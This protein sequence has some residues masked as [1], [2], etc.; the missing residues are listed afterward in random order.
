MAALLAGCTLAG[1]TRTT[2]RTGT[3]APTRSAVAPRPTATPT[4]LPEPAVLA[5]KLAAVSRSGIGSSGIVVLAEDGTRL[6]ARGAAHPLAPAST[7]KVLTTLAA[8]D[9]L[10]ADHRFTTRVVATSKQRVVLVG[11]GDP[12]L[13][14][15]QSKSAAKPASLQALAIATAAAL[16][17]SGVNRVQLGYDDSLFSGPDFNP[18]WKAKWRSWVARVSP[19]LIGEGRITKWQA[20]AAPA[21]TAAAAFAQQLRAAGIAVTSIKAAKAPAAA[22][23]LAKVSSAPLADVI[24]RTL[25][26]SDN[27]AAEVIAR[28]VAVAAGRPGSFTGAA[29]TLKSW[30]AGH[31][32]WSDG[33][34]VWDGSGLSVSARVTPEVLARAILASLAD[35]RLSAVASGLPVAG[36]TGTLKDRFDDKREVVARGNVHAKT[37]TLIGVA[38]LTGYLTTADGTRL[39]FAEIANARGQ[40]TAYNWLDRSAAVL[41][42]CG[43]R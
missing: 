8:V 24:G 17:A 33:M 19:L 30:L 5:R 28:Q 6:A 2:D 22:T 12:L 15:K 23:E 16:S 35:E 13:T 36:L 26:L 10:G 43:C 37:G 3:A 34:R 20:D 4:V 7:M 42:G 38:A 41:V 31:Q 29:A 18:H 11:G 39:V 14:D 21:R 27:L 9:T 1:A 32:L 25:R 40:T